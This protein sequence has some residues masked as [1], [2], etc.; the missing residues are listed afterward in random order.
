[1]DLLYTIPPIMVTWQAPRADKVSKIDLELV[2]E[3]F[4][5]TC[6]NRIDCICRFFKNLFTIR[7]LDPKHL[8]LDAINH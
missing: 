4:G 1:M 2:Q 3:D 7:G 8:T 6:K 5:K